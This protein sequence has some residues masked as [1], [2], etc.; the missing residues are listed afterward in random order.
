MSAARSNRLLEDKVWRA[1][2]TLQNARLLSSEDAMHLLSYYRLGSDIGLLPKIKD[3]FTSLIVDTQPGC[4][5]YILDRE[6]DL[7]QCD[8]ERA[9][10]VRGR[11]A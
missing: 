8:E 5:Q 6:L 9:K 10:L 4:L 3:C 1:R 2:A 7:G 11:T